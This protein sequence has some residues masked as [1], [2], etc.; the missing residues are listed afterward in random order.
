MGQTSRID[1]WDSFAWPDRHRQGMQDVGFR[2]RFENTLML[3]H[4][5]NLFL[6]GLPP[7]RLFAFRR[8]FLRAGGIN[9]SEGVCFCGRGWVYGRGRLNI[10]RNTWLSPGVVVHTHVEAEITI[11]DRCDI[12][13][14]VEFITGSHRIGPPSRRAGS[15][16]A[17]SIRV[18]NGCW[19]GA[20]ARILGGVTI[21]DGVVVAAGAVVTRD[22]PPHTLAAGV[23]ARI[24]RDLGQ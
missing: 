19:I 12:G 4:L 11:G 24:K 16:T 15:G 20:G 5:I 7:S 3:R 17:Q 14:S 9:A 2:L 22:I 21:G 10:G 13:P 23:P 18:G 1:P 6:W 8:A